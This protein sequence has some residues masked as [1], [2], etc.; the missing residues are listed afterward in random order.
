MG[1]RWNSWSQRALNLVV[2]WPEIYSSVSHVLLQCSAYCA[3]EVHRWCLIRKISWKAF[4]KHW[5]DLPGS[6]G[7]Q[8]DVVHPRL[9]EQPMHGHDG[10]GMAQ[11]LQGGARSL[12]WLVQG[13]CKR[14]T[15]EPQLWKVLS[16]YLNVRP[17]IIK[18]LEENIEHSMT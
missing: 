12:M 10:M 1:L 15:D 11:Y 17:E 5:R 9:R 7:K 13:T 16:K 14:V 18:L 6:F 4:Q 2:R 3:K 8:K